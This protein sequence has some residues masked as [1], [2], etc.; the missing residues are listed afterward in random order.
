MKFHKP[1][2][3]RADE[4][5]FEAIWKRRFCIVFNF[6]KSNIC[7]GLQDMFPNDARLPDNSCYYW[8]QRILVWMF[9]VNWHCSAISSL[10]RQTFRA[11]HYNIRIHHSNPPNLIKQNAYFF[12]KRPSLLRSLVKT[13]RTVYKM[14]S[15][16]KSKWKIGPS[17]VDSLL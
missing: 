6:R 2:S 14:I 12:T 15:K 10:V 16:Q 17:L 4:F 8:F 1:T 13:L 3:W 7:L 11:L 9:S 5:S